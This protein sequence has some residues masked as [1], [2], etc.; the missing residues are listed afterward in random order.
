MKTKKIS[1]I[2]FLILSL[3]FVLTG[4]STIGELK[5]ET[6]IND[7]LTSPD[8]PEYVLNQS[9][10][11]LIDE[12]SNTPNLDNYEWSYNVNLEDP[13]IVAPQAD[14][15]G[16]GVLTARNIV[17][18]FEYQIKGKPPTNSDLEPIDTG[19]KKISYNINELIFDDNKNQLIKM[20]TTNQS[21]SPSE[22]PE[23]SQFEANYSDGFSFTA[24]IENNTDDSL[25]VI[26]LG[27]KNLSD[28]DKALEINNDQLSLNTSFILDEPH[29]ASILVINYDQLFVEGSV[30]TGLNSMLI[31][32]P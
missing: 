2:L 32:V 24:T 13:N 30:Q 11:K 28:P 20:T 25:G 8:G 19:K 7:F 6:R 27:D 29:F 5:T 3:S 18:V 21:E 22:S 16:S 9:F 4:C 31:A 15:D 17:L 23:I 10:K 26:S 1:L 14:S 12:F